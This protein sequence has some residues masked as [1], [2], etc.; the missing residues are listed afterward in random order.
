MSIITGK[1]IN[2]VSDMAY[3]RAVTFLGE[4]VIR[5]GSHLR[6]MDDIIRTLRRKVKTE[7]IDV[8]VIDPF[9]FLEKPSIPNATD[10]EKISEMLTDLVDVMRELHVIVIMAAHPRKLLKDEKLTLYS[11]SGSSEFFNKPDN[12]MVM[13]REQDGQGKDITVFE[14]QKSRYKDVG[15]TGKFALCF[16][17]EN[18]RFY[19]CSE[20]TSGA[21]GSNNDLLRYVPDA[22]DDSDMLDLD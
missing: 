2:K 5:M 10:A 15:A 22:P 6:R 4:H 11:I 1:P 19:G 9:G 8:L 18:F 17:P 13:W 16:N 3:N 20:D 12:G 7:G 14:V 21:L